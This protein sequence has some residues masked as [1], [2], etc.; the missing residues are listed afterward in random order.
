MCT[1]NPWLT[2]KKV[3]P[4]TDVNLGGDTT[5]GAYQNWEAHRL[6]NNGRRRMRVIYAEDMMRM[7]PNSSIEQL[8]EIAPCGQPP[9]RADP[10]GQSWS[11]L[12][13]I[14]ALPPVFL[15]D[16]DLL[17]RGCPRR[18]DIHERYHS[19]S[20]TEPAIVSGLALRAAAW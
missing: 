18:A 10:E 8:D 16:A 5:Q 7:D 14:V 17:R 19:S 13:V 12:P 9:R 11:F 20:L 15:F 2:F 4:T 1:T 3:N 6:K